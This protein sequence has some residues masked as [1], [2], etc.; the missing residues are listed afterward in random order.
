MLEYLFDVVRG[1]W[2]YL[3][4][5]PPEARLQLRAFCA[6]VREWE[7]IFLLQYRTYLLNELADAH[8]PFIR[9]ALWVQRQWPLVD[10][11]VQESV[12]IAA[13]RLDD[14]RQG[15]ADFTDEAV[16]ISRTEDS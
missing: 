16:N 10:E 12:E 4:P 15:A 13:R 1:Q 11:Q 14:L 2:N 6:Q 5:E 7:Q 9:H 3:I 8:L